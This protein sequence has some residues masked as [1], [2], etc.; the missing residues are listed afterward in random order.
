MA[1]AAGAVEPLPLAYQTASVIA[2]TART[3]AGSA[4]PG[5]V[6]TNGSPALTPRSTPSS[7]SGL[8][9]RFTVVVYFHSPT[10]RRLRKS[11]NPE[12]VPVGRLGEPASAISV[13]GAPVLS[14]S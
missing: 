12:A 11:W 8:A 2:V 9:I 14:L 3:V 6:S 10:L 4:V 1:G 5:A 7:S 13:N